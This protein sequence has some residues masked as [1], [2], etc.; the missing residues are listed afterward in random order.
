DAAVPGPVFIQSVSGRC[1][2][3]SQ[4][5]PSQG[6]VIQLWDC[7]G[8]P[9]QR[10]TYR[11]HMFIAFGW[12]LDVSGA[13]TANG[14]GIWLWGCNG[15]GAQQW[16]ISGKQLLNPQSGRCLTRVNAGTDAGTRLEIRDCTNTPA[17]QWT[18]DT[19]IITAPV[20]TGVQTSGTTVTVT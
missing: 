4:G 16:V 6:A 18:T 12:C 13:G 17:Q 5:I 3:V 8:T 15:T 9:A 2:D 10:W 11:D 20:L 19:T 14:T 1:V 7:N